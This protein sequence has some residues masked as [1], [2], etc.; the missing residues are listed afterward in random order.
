MDLSDSP[1]EA[2][3]RATA[4]AFLD[5]HAHQAPPDLDPSEETPWETRL[6]T[7]KAWQRLLFDEG[8]VAIT[9]PTE[10]GGRGLGPVEQIIWNQEC[11][12]AK[13]PAPV[14]I[15]GIGMAGPAI[16]GHG[17]HDQQARHLAKILSG[18]E[19]WCQLFSEPGAGSDLA[20][21]ATRAERDGDTWVV[22]GQKVWS[23]GAHFAQWGILVARTD[24]TVPKHQGLTFFLVDMA[25][26]GVTV[27]PLR[28]MNGDTHF[29]EVFL[30][31]VRIPDANRLGEV[32][33][34]WKVV[35]TTLLH[36][37]MTL[38]GSLG[39]FH[40][41]DLLALARSHGPLSAHRARPAGPGVHRGP[42]PRAVEHADPLQAVRRRD[43]LRGGIDRQAGHGPHPH[44]G[45]RGRLLVARPRIGHRREPLAQPVPH[46]AGHPGGRGHRRD[47]EEH[48]G[49][50]G[51][52][53]AP[54]ERREPPTSLEPGAALLDRRLG[55]MSMEFSVALPMIGAD[56]FVP[57]ARACEEAGYG[58]VAVPESV[59][60]PEEVSAGYPY[61]PDGSR[62]WPPETPFLD[63]LV[64]I[65]AMAAV[66]TRLRFYT[67]VLKLAVRE[68][69]LVA[70]TVTSV[71]VLSGNR[72]GLGVGLSWIPEEFAWLGQEMR[73]RG[74]RTD[75]AIEILRLVGTGEFVDY[76]GRHYD[77]GRLMVR[78]VPSEPVPIYVGGLSEPGLRRAAR[79]GDGWISVLNTEAEL[80]EV[81][82]RLAVLRAELGRAN[83]PF[84]IKAI[85]S[86]VFD[87]DGFR[88]L[89]AIGVT[90]AMVCPWYYYPGDTDDLD[91]QRAGIE[92]FAEEV[93]Q[94]FG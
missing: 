79:L 81:I 64:A 75:E 55:G 91:H 67:N 57:L 2:A 14:G 68:P 93:V 47:A 8:W 92:R 39:V 54:R 72:L 11:L 61:T 41:E 23:S 90:D 45:R 84:E 46:R 9:W 94:R 28:Q 65:P 34:G 70:K 33:E 22:N 31:G 1:E 16:I 30:D 56:H 44:R 40:M 73:T 27:R 69:L 85:C 49:R 80:A 4:R 71:A 25:S 77:F 38:G 32:G 26:P 53:A 51:A 10:Y 7:L 15:V 6:A 60:F 36:E 35:T 37:R 58:A 63:P 52:R 50:A 29:N 3:F 89:E 5:R 18:D 43:P 21:L 88:R 66:T 19:L 87:Y 12:R 13:V 48:G 76:H 86:D 82:Q 78:P 17:S 59:F 83:V 24:P 62:F 74:A 42:L 20:T